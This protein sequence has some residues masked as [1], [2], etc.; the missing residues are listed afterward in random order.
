MSSWAHAHPMPDRTKR[1]TTFTCFCTNP[2]CS[3]SRRPHPITG[4]ATY[5]S[6]FEPDDAL[7]NECPACGADLDTTPLFEND[8]EYI[9]E[10]WQ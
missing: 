1:Y 6:R 2:A 5:G 10:E 3:H 7:P 8:D 9:T 4:V